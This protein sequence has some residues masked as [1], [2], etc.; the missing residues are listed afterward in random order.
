MEFDE[1]VT[2]QLRSWRVKDTQEQQTIEAKK[3]ELEAQG[4]T[5]DMAY[6]QKLAQEE[7]SYTKELTQLK[8]LKTELAELRRSRVSLLRER[9][10]A[11]EQI[12]TIRDAYARK[13]SVALKESLH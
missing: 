11:R 2:I 4:I 1:Q 10:S 5:L 9:W 6:I 7:A 13:A 12:A 8:I 3:K